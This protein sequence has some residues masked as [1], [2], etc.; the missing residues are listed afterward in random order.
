M[1]GTRFTPVNG[2]IT[3]NHRVSGGFLEGDKFLNKKLS[4]KQPNKI[5]LVVEPK[6]QLVQQSSAMISNQLH[7]SG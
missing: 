5:H 2:Q 7:G 3:K 4:A 1:E 6:K